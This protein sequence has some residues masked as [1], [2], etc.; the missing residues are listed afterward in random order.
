MKVAVFT[1]FL[2][3]NFGTVLQAVA[4]SLILKQN[5]VS[6]TFIQWHFFDQSLIKK[7]I[8]LIRHPFF[9]FY[10]KKHRKISKK[11]LKYD[12]MKEK[13]FQKTLEKNRLFVLENISLSNQNLCI[14]SLHTLNNLFDKFIIGSDQ[15]WSPFLF[16]RYSPHFLSFIDDKNKKVSYG[17]SLGTINLP[18]DFQKFIKKKLSSF[19]WISCREQTN[20]NFLGKLL[21]RNIPCVLDPT[22]LLNKSDWEKFFVKV[23]V[24]PNYILCYILGEKECISDYAKKLSQKLRMP[25]YFIA[26]RPLHQKHENVLNGI[27][28]KEFLY[29][30]AN[31]SCMVTDSF[32][33]TI[34]SINFH[35]NF[36]SFDKHPNES[37]DNGRLQEM[38]SLLD[39]TSHYHKDNDES[40][41][42][43]IDY[44]RVENRLERLRE[45]SFKYIEN[46]LK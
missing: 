7:I 10:I 41:P 26:T 36:I 44:D 35:R 31:C 3:Q 34:F 16:Y 2:S 42:S 15:T 40:F 45:N 46:I 22:L 30:I 13:E 20:C 37:L 14:D 6:A 29:L 43:E 28:C 21:N 38:L 33:G 27:G 1:P 9:L 19:K 5:N 17:C 24:P 39:L 12:F 11:D 18:K 23:D 25:I 32:H 4:F 8:F